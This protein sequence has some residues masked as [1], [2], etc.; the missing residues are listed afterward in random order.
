MGGRLLGQE[1]ASLAA[2]LVASYGSL[3][4]EILEIPLRLQTGTLRELELY[5]NQIPENRMNAIE[6]ALHQNRDV[7]KAARLAAQLVVPLMR[8][9][10]PATKAVQLCLQ[11]DRTRH[12]CRPAQPQRG[13]R[14]GTAR[15]T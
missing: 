13:R 1:E 5:G 2:C 3:L 6:E 8:F 14:S 9:P 10:V 12:P 7:R 4:L 11:R 15:S